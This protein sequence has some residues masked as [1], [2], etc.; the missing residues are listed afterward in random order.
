[1]DWEKLGPVAYNP[2]LEKFTSLA[3]WNINLVDYGL[4]YIISHVNMGI[5][6]EMCFEAN[7][8]V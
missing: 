5:V 4:V 8:G 2:S 7:L 6:W 3:C 1:M